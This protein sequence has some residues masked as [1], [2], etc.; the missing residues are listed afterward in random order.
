M[1][2]SSAPCLPDNPSDVVYRQVIAVVPTTTILL[3]AVLTYGLRIVARAQTRQ[4]IWWDDY[5]MGVGLL[6]SFEPA[7]CQ[8]LRKFTVTYSSLRRLIANMVR[9]QLSQM[10]LVIM[11]AICPRTY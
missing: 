2:A 6:L 5:L 11:C 7:I 10:A 3:L 4:K 9:N 1:S 8:Y